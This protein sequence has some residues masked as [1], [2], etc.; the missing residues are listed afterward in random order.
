LIFAFEADSKNSFPA[1]DNFI[2]FR[3]LGDSLIT[4]WYS[5]FLIKGS[6]SSLGELNPNENNLYNVPLAIEELPTHQRLRYL[7]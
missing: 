6:N 7:S 3:T 1:L 2:D 5:L 4:S